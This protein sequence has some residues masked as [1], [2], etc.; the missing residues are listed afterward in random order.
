MTLIKGGGLIAT[1]PNLE[2]IINPVV[3]FSILVTNMMTWS[4]IVTCVLLFMITWLLYIVYINK[5]A[6]DKSAPRE[7]ANL[8]IPPGSYGLPVIGEVI[9]KLLNVSLLF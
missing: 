7:I 1:I 8:P 6:E 2:K 3:T 4:T 5:S 9:S